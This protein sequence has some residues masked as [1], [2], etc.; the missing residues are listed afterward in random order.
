MRVVPGV[1]RGAKIRGADVC[2][3]RVGRSV[4][5]VEITTILDSE[6][7]TAD[8]GHAAVHNSALLVKRLGDVEQRA[9]SF[10]KPTL[11]ATLL[12]EALLLRR[13]VYRI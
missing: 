2:V 13:V 12:E 6:V 5:P 1:R 11:D 10:I 4:P 9:T 8:E 3:E 7:Y